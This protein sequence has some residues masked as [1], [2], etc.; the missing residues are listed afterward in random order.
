MVGCS[1]CS[2]KIR[3]KEKSRRGLSLS[4]KVNYTSRCKMLGVKKKSTKV[5]GN[6][7]SAA[8]MC[9]AIRDVWIHARS[10]DNEPI[11]WLPKHHKP[12]VHKTLLYPI[13]L[14]LIINP[15][16]NPVSD[17]IKPVFVDLSN[18]KLL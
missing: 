14:F 18:S 5:R 8:D 6:C 13:V 10:I 15:V 9:K 4:F 1:T 2:G 16:P 17:A 11:H 7:H 12:G 3:I